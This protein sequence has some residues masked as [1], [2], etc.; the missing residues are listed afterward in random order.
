MSA[1]PTARKGKIARLP[2]TI[3]ERINEMLRDNVNGP[4]ILAWANAEAKLDGDASLTPQNLSVWREGGFA[5]W[6]DKQEKVDRVQ[7]LSE[8]AL[9]LA[10][11]S[12]GSTNS[13]A[14]AIAGG[15]VLEILE[16]FD[17][18]TQKE[19]LRAK[20]ELFLDLLDR[21][22]RLQRSSVEERKAAQNE[23]KLQ[24]GERRLALE[25]AR[26]QRQ[27]AELFLKFYEDKRAKEIAEGKGTS[28]VKIEQ[29]KLLMFGE[30]PSQEKADE[31]ART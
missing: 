2:R 14:S 12:G 15:Q 29:L 6:L 11:A 3:R 28:D 21:I 9:R 17:V 30:D 31:S 13:T 19:L 25:E 1:A 24:Q 7:Q 8:Y 20:P 4:E 23:V 18:E 5:E 16:D 22:S 26:F 27:T 10:T